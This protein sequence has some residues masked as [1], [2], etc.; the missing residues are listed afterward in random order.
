MT[1]TSIV[2]LT[3]EKKVVFQYR[4]PGGDIFS[5]QKLPNGRILFGRYAGKLAELDRAGKKVWEVDIERQNMGLVTLEVVPGGR[6]LMPYPKT[7]RVVE[8][9]RTGKVVWQANVEQPTSVAR[10][11]DGNLLV[12]SHMRNRV[13][14]IDRRG[15]VLWEQKAEGQIFRVRVR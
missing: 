2:E 3:R 4:E 9:D 13:V 6:I 15:R 10:L 7:N 11:P 8:V 12:G 14:E 5:G 1:N